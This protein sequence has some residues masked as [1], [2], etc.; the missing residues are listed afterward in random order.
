MTA[1]PVVLLLAVVAIILGIALAVQFR[2][3]QPGPTQR[4]LTFFAGC[5]AVGCLWTGAMPPAWCSGSGTAFLIA[6]ALTVTAFL[7][8]QGEE[9]AFGRP[10]LL[11]MGLTLLT[12]NLI[13]YFTENL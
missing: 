5:A 11:G 3:V 2:W 6:T 4:A 1:D 7:Y 8:R 13:A 12:A 10:L 9:R